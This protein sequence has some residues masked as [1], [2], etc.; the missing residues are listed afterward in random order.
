MTD[1]DR[2]SHLPIGITWVY[3]VCRI[4]VYADSNVACLCYLFQG[5]VYYSSGDKIQHDDLEDYSGQNSDDEDDQMEGS[6]G[7]W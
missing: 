3:V 6:A 4:Q 5:D 7:K 2:W 1:D